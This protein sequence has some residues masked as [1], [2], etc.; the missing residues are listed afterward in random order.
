MSDLN[1]RMANCIY[2]NMEEVL[3]S[4]IAQMKEVN[5]EHFFKYFHKEQIDKLSREFSDIMVSNLAITQ[6]LNGVS[7]M[8]SQELTEFAERSVRFGWS[9][10][11]VNTAIEIFVSIT[12]SIVEREK[13]LSESNFS[14]AI[15]L[16]NNWAA[17]LRLGVLETYTTEWER[18]VTLQKAALQELSASLIPIFDKV[19]VMPLVGAIDTERSKV[20]ME[21]LLKGIVKQ[22]VEVVLIDI[23]DVPIVDTMVA[24]HLIQ[25]TEAVRLIG[26]KCMLVGIR[27]EIAQTIVALGITLK[28][29][30]T[31]STLQVGVKE[32]LRLT[33][34]EIVEVR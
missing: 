1:K 19:S 24:H 10:K 3:V 22:R 18:T 26:A 2:E 12:F 8:D 4:W 15:A 6:N 14:E 27:P 13:V 28:D 21:N 20:I 25:A 16:L 5:R 23:T 7:T 11:F 17:A 31:T 32:A 34:R 29:F 9:A 30:T 33:N